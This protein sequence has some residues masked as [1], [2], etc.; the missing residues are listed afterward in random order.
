MRGAGAVGERVF[1]GGRRGAWRRAVARRLLAAGLAAGAVLGCLAVARAPEGGPRVSVVVAA[2][3]LPAG[4]EVAAGD[5]VVTSRPADYAPSGA[6]SSAAS[7]VG[8]RLA[9]PVTAGEVMTEGRVVGTG[10]LSARPAGE[11][12]AHVSVADPGALAMVRPGDSVDVVSGAGA[13]VAH[14]ATV[15]AVG[16]AAGPEAAG[17]GLMDDPAGPGL[18]LAVTAEVAARLAS[19]PAHETGGSGLTVVLRRP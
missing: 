17:L 2:R 10:L 7:L 11:V 6:P 16:P 12:A 3:G 19:A 1:G 8:R 14:S 5:L 4:H 13:T 15:L 9:G 18:V